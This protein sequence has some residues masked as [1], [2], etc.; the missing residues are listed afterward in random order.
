MLKIAVDAIGGDYGYE[1]TVPACVQFLQNSTQ[2]ELTVVGDRTQ[3][4]SVIKKQ[5][6]QRLG[7]KEILS[8]LNIKHTD[9]LGKVRPYL[10]LERTLNAI[11]INL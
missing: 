3:I 5:L 11:Q 9:S 10:T 2:V 1:V 4:Q 7:N 8:R 6:D